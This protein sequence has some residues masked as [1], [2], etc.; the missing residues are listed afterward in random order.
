MIF[1]ESV[2]TY[3]TVHRGQAAMSWVDIARALG[4]RDPEDRGRKAVFMVYRN[5]MKK[6]R[7]NPDLA[8]RF[9]YAIK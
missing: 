9:V 6:L 7:R 3:H 1:E 4:Y 5:A 8:K 2:M